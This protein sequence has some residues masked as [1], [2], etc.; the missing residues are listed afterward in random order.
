MHCGKRRQRVASAQVEP[1][2]RRKAAAQ[3][4]CRVSRDWFEVSI[5]VFALCPS[6]VERD[7]EN[8]QEI[9]P[10]IMRNN[11]RRVVEMWKTMRKRKNISMVA[12]KLKK[13]TITDLEGC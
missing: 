12:E 8:I 5:M 4:P 6:Q 11:P 2:M 1:A 13:E 3:D 10:E 7:R 9:K